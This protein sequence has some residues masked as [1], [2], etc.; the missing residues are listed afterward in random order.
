[1]VFGDSMKVAERTLIG[2]ATLEELRD[3]ARNLRALTPDS[4]LAE[5]VEAKIAELEKPR[6]P[7][8]VPT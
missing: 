2:G 6:V 1:M 7:R 5:L 8:A 4:A 3:A